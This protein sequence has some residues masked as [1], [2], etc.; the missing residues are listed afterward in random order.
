M[1]NAAI[2]ATVTYTLREESGATTTIQA[3]SLSDAE[4]RAR[5]WVSEGDYPDAKP[6]ATTWCRVYKGATATGP[7]DAI[8]TV[9]IGPET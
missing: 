2:D 8:V 4:E 7:A 6:G 9:T 1:N 5:E 3:S